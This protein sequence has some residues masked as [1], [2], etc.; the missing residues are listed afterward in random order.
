MGLLP[1]W[2][3]GE[4]TREQQRRDVLATPEG[5]VVEPGKHAFDPTPEPLSLGR[6]YVVSR[7]LPQP[8][9]QRLE[10]AW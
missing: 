4:A 8:P 2:V 10:A 9:R 6:G 3:V 5:S 1:S 7:V